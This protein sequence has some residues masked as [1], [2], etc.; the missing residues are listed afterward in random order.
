[1]GNL[2]IN[3]RG[4]AE[5]LMENYPFCWVIKAYSTLNVQAGLFSV[6]LACKSGRN[7]EYK[8]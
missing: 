7:V 4:E 2:E 6:N 3:E 1:M 5:S 8:L